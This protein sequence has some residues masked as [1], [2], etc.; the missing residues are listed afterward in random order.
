MNLL[1][2]R[3]LVTETPTV[4]NNL[5]EAFKITPT[6]TVKQRKP[7]KPLRKSFLDIV[8]EESKKEVIPR[9]FST[10]S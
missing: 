9:P 1:L 6:G 5:Q 10:L 4:L 2:Q 3:N 7:R 8:E